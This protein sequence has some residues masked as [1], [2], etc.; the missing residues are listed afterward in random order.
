MDAPIPKGEATHCPTGPDVGR[1]SVYTV[2][3]GWARAAARKRVRSSAVKYFRPRAS[4]SETSRGWGTGGGVRAG[5]PECYVSHGEMTTPLISP[6]FS[7]HL[8]SA[9]AAAAGPSMCPEMFPNAD[10]GTSAYVP[11][12]ATRPAPIASAPVLFWPSG[13]YELIKS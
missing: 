1:A 9:I 12:G 5:A 3:L 10:S 8:S 6:A 11:E 7:G 4:T 2:G 13:A